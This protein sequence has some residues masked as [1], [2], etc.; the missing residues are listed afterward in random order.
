MRQAKPDR[1]TEK[2]RK[3]GAMKEWRRNNH[4]KGQASV[5]LAIIGSAVI[6]LLAYLVQQGY[7]YNSRQSLEMY[8]FRQALSQSREQQ[9]G[10]TLTVMRDVIVPSFFSSLNRQRLM[11][12]AS[13]DLNSYK[14][15]IPDKP[16]DIPSKQLL[17]I[18]EAMIQN[19]LFFEVP[20]TKVKIVT[21]RNQG[22]E[23]NKQWLWVNSAVRELD[24]N[25]EH[26]QEK[27]AI[28][29]YNITVT[30]DEYAKT[31][32]KNLS[33]RDKVSTIITFENGTRIIKSYNDD[34]WTPGSDDD[35]INSVDVDVGTIPKDVNLGLEE[36]VT[37]S[38]ETSTEH[39]STG[40][41]GGGGGDCWPN[42]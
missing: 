10:V 13:V 32:G 22:E 19:K 31:I 29:D 27:T 34:N 26:G 8:A 4:K 1:C 17:Q 3:D 5:E 20:P 2:K 42:C 41:G 24:A 39:P 35:H 6:I 36:T 16:Q 38:K 21:N 7:L 30:E 37:R 23:E 12:S 28:Y 18:G 33:S 25:I 11:A 15:Y 40:G 9:R 14:L